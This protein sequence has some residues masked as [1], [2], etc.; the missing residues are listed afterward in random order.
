[1]EIEVEF[2][3]VINA[4][5]DEEKKHLFEISMFDFTA[6]R[7]GMSLADFDIV[8]TTL[9]DDGIITTNQ[10]TSHREHPT[11]SLTTKGILL[12]LKGGYKI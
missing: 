11:Y 9:K 1:M 10:I 7:M 6:E 4:L 5:Y 3:K 8:I 12:K 2:N